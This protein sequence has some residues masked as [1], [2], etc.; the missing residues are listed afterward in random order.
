MEKAQDNEQY[1]RIPPA[2]R[3]DIFTKKKGRQMQERR[4]ILLPAPFL[5]KTCHRMSIVGTGMRS[6]GP[7]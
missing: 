6:L 4:R 3:K 7:V 5:I 2:D 1:G